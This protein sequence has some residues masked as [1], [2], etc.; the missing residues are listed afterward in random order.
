MFVF[1][2][3]TGRW[4]EL[5]MR[6]R[7][8][9]AL[10]VLMRRIPSSVER[11]TSDGIFERV[12]VRN[13][14]VDDLIRVLP[15]EA[16]PADGTIKQGTTNADEALLTGESRAVFKDVGSAIIAGSHNLTA[17]VQ[18][19]IEKLGQSTRYS[20]IVAL[21][22]RVAVDKPR[23]AQIA[24]RI[25]KPFLYAVIMAAVLAAALLWQTDHSRALMAAVAV[26]I[27]TCP[28]ALSLATPAA[29]LTI[30]GALARSG[31]LVRKMQALEALTKID[32]IVFDKTGTLTE[33]RMQISAITC[34]ETL[35]ENDALK[36]AA[37]LAQNSLH[38]VSKALVEA[39]KSRSIELD[40]SEIQDVQ[41]VSGSGLN[42]SSI[43]GALK[44][45]SSAFCGLDKNL[46]NYRYD[47]CC[48]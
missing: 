15:G 2:L 48:F 6:D 16:F 1:F 21:M 18:L 43:Y 40:S 41:E 30:T 33:S 26:L 23:L 27:V 20:E 35:H 45:G 12:A 44:L 38:P 3:L 9:G 7:T 37:N 25:A 24:D 14:R 5:R 11:L 19:Q 46:R 32:T 39:A 28:C 13:L 22:E 4:L 47:R 42:A 8:A 17:T 36:I 31:V 34:N 10:D 29:M